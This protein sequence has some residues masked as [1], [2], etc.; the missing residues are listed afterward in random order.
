MAVKKDNETELKIMRAAIHVFHKKGVHGARMQEIADQA[1][2]N[3]ALL[4]YYFLNKEHLF[5][6]V[7]ED[8]VMKIFP[9]INAVL[10]SDL[11]LM[12]KIEVFVNTYT[13]ILK[14]HYYSTGFVIAELNFNAEKATE[15]MVK[16]TGWDLSVLEKQ[17]HTAIKQGLIRPI[18]TKVLVVNMFSL[19]IFP[20]VIIPMFMKRFNMSESEYMAFLDERKKEV[21][22]M[23]INYIKKE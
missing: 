3:K 19:I 8:T 1:G 4:H 12:L 7:F 6:K 18:D 10:S 23:I 14:E 16:K 9:K 17:V 21:I 20:F 22:Q 11:P 13:D 5:E 2:I 15:L